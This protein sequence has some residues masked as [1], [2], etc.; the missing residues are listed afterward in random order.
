MTHGVLSNGD[1]LWLKA[2]FDTATSLRG[3]SALKFEEFATAVTKLSETP[4]TDKDL[5]AAFSEFDKDNSGDIDFDEFAQLYA[6]VK[7]GDVHGLSNPPLLHDVLTPEDVKNLS[8]SF[9]SGQTTFPPRDYLNKEEF[10]KLVIEMEGKTV[11]HRCVACVCVR[12]VCGVCLYVRACVCVC[13]G[14]VVLYLQ[15]LATLH[16]N[17]IMFIIILF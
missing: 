12:V 4:P 14:G 17:E 5:A 1:M 7:R 9:Y 6:S 8:N 13:V 16:P 10:I 2:E 11:K 15:P 3:G